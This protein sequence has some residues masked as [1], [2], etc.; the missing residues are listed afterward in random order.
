MALK[1]PFIHGAILKREKNA[2][3][4]TTSARSGVD[5]AESREALLGAAAESYLA[6]GWTIEVLIAQ[7]ISP[8]MVEKIAAY[9]AAL[10]TQQ[11]SDT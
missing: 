10:P 9:H 11:G 2:T 4:T 6:Q 8:D 5:F 1:I 3:T 7:P